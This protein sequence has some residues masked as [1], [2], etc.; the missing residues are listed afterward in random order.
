MA[1]KRMYSKPINKE[2]QKYL[3]EHDFITI[4]QCRRVFYNTESSGYDLARRKLKAMCDAGKVNR[5]RPTT[6]INEKAIYYYKNPTPTK[7][8]IALMDFYAEM[9]S[10]KRDIVYFKPEFHI[11]DSKYSVDGIMVYKDKDCDGD[12]AYFPLILE[13]ERTH[14]TTQSRLDKIY[15]CGDIQKFLKENFNINIYPRVVIITDKVPKV[16]ST[17]DY[18]VIKIPLNMEGFRDTILK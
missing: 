3:E 4:D 9:K 10:S 15:D 8:R 5:Y 18:Q 14:K 12:Y 1:D 6:N 2:I 13:V 11:A 7:S 16:Q 17:V